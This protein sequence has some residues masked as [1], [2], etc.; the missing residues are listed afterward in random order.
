MGSP[1]ESLAEVAAE[2]SSSFL[3]LYWGGNN[4]QVPMPGSWR[5]AC[6]KHF[7]T[8]KIRLFF[9]FPLAEHS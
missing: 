7:R 4:H 6:C 2:P 8:S 1:A 9:F 5:D 3:S